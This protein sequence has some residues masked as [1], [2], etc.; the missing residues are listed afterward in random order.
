[1]EVPIVPPYA[2]LNVRSL[3][4]HF[5][6]P[7]TSAL[8]APLW[9][10]VPEEHRGR[11]D[12][13]V[14]H[15]WNSLSF[16]PPQQEIGTLDAIEHLG[17]YAWIDFVAYNQHTIESIPTDMEA[18]IG[19]IGKVIFAGTPVPTLGRIWCLWESCAQIVLEP[20]STSASDPA[21]ATIRSGGEHPLPIVRR[22]REG[23]RNEATGSQNHFRRGNCPV[24]LN[25]RSKRAPRSSPAR[26]VLRQLV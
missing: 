11:P 23:C 17:Q 4:D 2:L 7:L 6:L 3:V 21:F 26:T 20:I 12:Y 15:T 1:M 13:F 16:G 10:C 22:S 9:A 8:R 19:E 14:S 5:V 25:Q 18:V 24:R